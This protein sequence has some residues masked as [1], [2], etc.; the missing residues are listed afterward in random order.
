MF[1]CSCSIEPILILSLISILFLAEI[2]RKMIEQIGY[3][4][5]SG[6][7]GFFFP[8]PVFLFLLHDILADMRRSFAFVPFLAT[9]FF[10]IVFDQS[11]HAKRQSRILQL[12]LKLP[13]Y[14]FIGRQ[15]AFHKLCTV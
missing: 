5:Y 9:S 7:M 12:C 15:R 11:F 1:S 8:F 14:D 3:N 4:P 13:Y 10:Y 2:Y 6:V